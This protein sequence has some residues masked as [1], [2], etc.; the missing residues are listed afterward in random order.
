MASA[1]RRGY[2][3][4]ERY[5]CPRV[6]FLILNS[7]L[8]PHPLL[9]SQGEGAE[10]EAPAVKVNYFLIVVLCGR[11]RACFLV[12]FR[13]F[14]GRWGGRAHGCGCGCGLWPLM[15]WSVAAAQQ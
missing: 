5:I 4:E 8:S 12:F 9:P 6:C 1:T 14:G 7:D 15:L 2:E 11:S 13:A 10:G 3:T